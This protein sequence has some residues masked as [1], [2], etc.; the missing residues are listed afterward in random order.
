MASIFVA[1]V[2]FGRAL[3]NYWDLY[4]GNAQLSYYSPITPRGYVF[5]LKEK[6]GLSV[7]WKDTSQ[8]RWI[9]YLKLHEIIFVPYKIILK[10]IA[11]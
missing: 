11:L 7:W 6:P 1:Q 2:R 4:K 3:Y 5:S 8:N 9:L 10:Y